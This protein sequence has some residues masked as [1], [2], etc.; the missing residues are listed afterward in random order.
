MN[1]L[2]ISREYPPSPYP[3]GGIGTYV[4]HIA[5]LLAARGET[6]H[7]IGQLWPGA[8]RARE[9]RLS[10]RLIVHRVPLDEP[11]A[12]A[13][14][15]P[16]ILNRL[17]RSVPC[18][19][20]L[21]NAAQLAEFLVETAGIDII[22]AQD[23]EAPA[24]LLL[25]RRSL[26]LGPARHVPI[27]VHLHT[28]TELVLKANE[29]EQDLAAS[30]PLAHLEG[31]AIRAADALLSPSRF[32]ARIAESHYQLETGAVAVIPYPMGD[33]AP[34]QRDDATWREGTIFYAG[35]LEPRKG[36]T[37]WIEAAIPVARDT[38]AR[39]A[40]VGGDTPLTG[41]RGGSVRET[42]CGRIPA[43]LRQRFQFF[44][45]VPRPQLLA[46][47]VR[48]RV[49]VVPSRF[50][51]FPYACVEAMASGLPV[52]VSPTGGMAEMIEDG[53]T[54]WIADGPDARSL[55]AAL[56][57]A[58][59]TPPAILER[60]GA[61]AAGSIRT[62]CDNRDIVSRQL[63]FRERVVA[64]GCRQ[65]TEVP[66][67]LALVPNDPRTQDRPG[68]DGIPVPGRTMSALDILRASPRQQLAVVRRALANPGYVA[69]W[70][71]WHGRC[72]ITRVSQMLRT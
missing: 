51:N 62:L 33:T 48:A 64:L 43:A 23:Y 5:E 26:G 22:E 68:E 28:P 40:F 72:A 10:G 20:F 34:L 12:E 1:H 3:A 7:V 70:L 35:R 58:L 11:S 18:S 39:F 14:M 44:D 24:Y 17:R 31:C 47:L 49:A 69:Q 25:L 55:E 27:V 52:I 63:A 65:S 42:L 54:G 21:R 46:H 2:I 45:A 61:A 67:P 59:A 13:D 57:R 37:E 15:D 53:R 9:T 41:S 56:R 71:A 50:E 6:V 38:A 60:M 30:A 29:W 36:V 19:G 4:G 66:L 32:L 16:A 8:T